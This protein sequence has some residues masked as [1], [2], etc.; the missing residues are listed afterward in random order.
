MIAIP[1]AI[2]GQKD[3]TE[4]DDFICASNAHYFFYSLKTSN[5]DRKCESRQKGCQSKTEGE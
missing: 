5:A 3:S 2:L 4:K 1:F